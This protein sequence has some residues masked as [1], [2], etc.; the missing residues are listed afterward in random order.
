MTLADHIDRQAAAAPEKA[1]LRFAGATWTYS[2]FAA[3]I[4]AVAAGLAALGLGRGDR[5]A[6]LGFNS[7]DM[8]TLFYAC[9]RLG[10]IFLP[11]NWRLAPPEHAY[12]VSHAAPKALAYEA[13]FAGQI[14][15]LEAAAPGLA[16]LAMEAL[17]MAAGPAP[18]AGLLGD[19][20][21]LVYTS[22]T[23][24]R[25]KGALLTQEAI[26]WNAAA[27]L[28][29]HGLTR[30]DH[31]LT[32]L[33]MFHVGGLNIQTTPALMYGATVTI[34]PRF[35]PDDTFD[36]LERE[37]PSLLV[38]VPAT[39]EALIGHPRWA[40][41]DL[42]SLRVLTTGS[43][44]VA[45]RLVEACAARGLKVIQVYGSTETCPIVVYERHGVPRAR[46]G[47][48]GVAGLFHDLRVV[49]R[50][51]REV[52]PDVHGEI[53]VRGPNLFSGYWRDPEA[54]RAAFHDG[55]FRTGDIGSVDAQGRLT[56]HDRKKNV[57]ISGGENVY[58]AEVERVILDFPGVV[59]CAVVGKPDPRWQE[60]PVA[61]VVPAKGA[62]FDL[63]ALKAHLAANLARYKLP[64][65]FL[66][67]DG[68]PRNAMGKA[69]HFVLKKELEAA[70]AA[71]RR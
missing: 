22:G 70:A 42:S 23:T 65:E 1:A 63:D 33:P 32:V 27:S 34:H 55:F 36:A 16:P 48:T 24:G 12:I 64:R 44:I 62:P 43:T 50:G 40:T 71:E 5:L 37:R 49:D 51:D 60:T 11:L 17:P 28:D 35:A 2:G 4:D 38:L 9:A 21:L 29:M 45:E 56:V 41:A 59:E 15:A 67:R 46:P 31:V 26:V 52:G 6:H 8:L 14:A 39:I 3:R 69:Q 19:P 7:A 61:F 58:P 54:T 47:A 10:A 20:T 66:L 53:L 25:P 13:S 18:R 68:L 30:S 57:V